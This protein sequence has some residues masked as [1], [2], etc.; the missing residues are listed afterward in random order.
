M[1]KRDM[2]KRDMR[3]RDMRKRDMRK[4]DMRKRERERERDLNV[5]T[6]IFFAWFRIGHSYIPRF[7]IFQN[8]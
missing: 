7:Y 4:R 6:V 8:I 5:K 3:K 2:R 1:R